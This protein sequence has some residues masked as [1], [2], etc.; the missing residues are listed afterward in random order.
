MAAHGVRGR[1]FNHLYLRGALI[2]R[3]WP[4]AGRLPFLRI[5]PEDWPRERRDAYFRAISSPEGWAALEER[6]RFDYALVSRRYLSRYGLLDLLDADRRW[7][8]V[9]VDDV[10]A[11]YVRREGPLAAVA[12]TFGYRVLPGG[13]ARMPALLRAAAAD[14]VTRAALETELTRQ[15]AQ[16]PM[17]LRGRQTLRSLPPT[18]PR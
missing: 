14:T 5:H 18:G 1:G 6:Y 8:L 7:A 15:A 11:L 4:D 13:T 9:F 2:F 12:D 17:N 3:F 16:S 10:A